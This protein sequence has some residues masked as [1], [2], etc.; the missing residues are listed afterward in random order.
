MQ[1]C[2]AHVFTREISQKRFE[3]DRNA[4]K[5]NWNCSRNCT[6]RFWYKLI[7]IKNNLSH[8]MRSNP[9]SCVY[10]SFLNSSGVI[11]DSRIINWRFFRKSVSRAYN[12]HVTNLKS[13]KSFQCN[14]KIIVQAKGFSQFMALFNFEKGP[15]DRIQSCCWAKHRQIS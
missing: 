10:C 12:H 14:F 4:S 13:W 7:E 11:V 6:R 1:H 15:Y 9:E 3:P 5:N 8:K 2:V